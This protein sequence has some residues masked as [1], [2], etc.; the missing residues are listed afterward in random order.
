MAGRSRTTKQ[1]AQRINLDYFK[2]SFALPLW[3]RRLS[4]GLVALGLLWLG[5]DALSGK[6]AYNAGPLSQGHQI[7]ASNCQACHVQ[8]GAWSMKARDAACTSCHNAPAHQAKQVFTPSCMSCHVE[9]QGA[10][11]LAATSNASCTQCHAEL[12]VKD[13][14]T[15]F[16][17]NIASFSQG[18]PEIVAMRPGHAVDPGTIK[19]NHQ[20]HMKKD[21]RG[22][23]GSPVQ[24]ECSSCHQQLHEV[25]SAKS[26]APNMA[27]VNFEAHCMSC[28]PLVFDSRFKDAAPHKE[29]RIV[30]EYVVAQYTSY[31]ATHP[32]AVHEP[33]RLN[34]LLPGR[35]IAP[36]PRNA[37]EWIAQQTEEAERLLWQKSCKEC[38]QLT[39]PAP[40]SRP[41]V[42]MASEN[43]RW[44]MNASFDHT[45]HQLVACTECH[46][47]ALSSQKTEDVLL[48]NIA[49][50]QKC[51]HEGQNAARA[52]CSECHTYHD[53]YQAKPVRS[54]NSISQFAR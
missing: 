40:S 28:H 29:T 5:W 27:P 21:L 39:Y 38:H 50:C 31:I 11:R 18:H 24:L 46:G 22:P 25:N 43:V 54:T 23:D 32:S 17:K 45:S 36:P 35:A 4:W 16:A 3:K 6:H 37:Q 14:Q 19:L 47:Q 9:H 41:E 49:T 7:V 26:L 2:K 33:V 8:Q 42:P 34:P 30:R 13:G 15:A 1:R 12:K 52:E 53:W 48:P 51:H 10:V 44:M 20:I